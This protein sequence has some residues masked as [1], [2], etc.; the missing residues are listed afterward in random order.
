MN[1]NYFIFYFY[2]FKFQSGLKLLKPVMCGQTVDRNMTG[3]LHEKFVWEP[4]VCGNDSQR[5]RSNDLHAYSFMRSFLVNNSNA[6]QTAYHT[7]MC[8]NET[9]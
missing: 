7:R 4:I 8:W 2:F 1:Q 3:L 9:F 6:P 5:L